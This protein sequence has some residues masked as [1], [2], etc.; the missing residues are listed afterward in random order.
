MQDVCLQ[1][2]N[3]ATR[4]ELTE[5]AVNKLMSLAYMNS[6][7]NAIHLLKSVRLLIFSSDAECVNHLIKSLCIL[8]ESSSQKE[9]AVLGL[10]SLLDSL[11]RS[12]FK[13]SNA[14]TASTGN[15]SEQNAMLKMVQKNVTLSLHIFNVLK[16]NFS[17]LD[18]TFKS[19]FYQSLCILVAVNDT[20]LIKPVAQ[21]LTDQLNQFTTQNSQT[22]EVY[23]N[24]KKSLVDGTCLK[25]VEPVDVLL[26]VSVICY[27]KGLECISNHSLHEA[28]SL[29]VG[30]KNL[31]KTIAKSYLEK[32]ASAIFEMYRVQ[33]NS[34]LEYQVDKLASIDMVQQIQ[35]G[36]YDSIMEYLVISNSYT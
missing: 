12:P 10:V 20:K 5:L 16:S 15:Q 22:R 34:T 27:T 18:S 19:H 9:I 25:I 32:E 23:F 7:S 8:V 29:L 11:N 13:V 26:N 21:F 30:L 35:Y 17:A 2:K 14:Y 4:C 36:L 1:E 28:F 31:V 33:L 6:T 3:N 24:L